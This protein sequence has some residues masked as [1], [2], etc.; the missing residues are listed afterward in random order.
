MNSANKKNILITGGAGYIGS[1]MVLCA[2]Q[3]G[4]N[5]VVLDSLVNGDKKFVNQKAK[6]IVGD[7]GDEAL[8]SRIISEEKISTIMHFAAFIEAGESVKNPEKYF[9]NNYEKSKILIETVV[10]LGVSNFIFSSTA[11][12]FGEAKYLPIDEEH[13]QDPIN[14]Y[15]KSKLMVEEFLA[16]TA[17]NN[18]H[19][20]YVCLRYFNACG[21]DYKNGLGENHNPETHLIPLLIKFVL[22]KRDEFFVNG[23]DYKTK[24][25][26]CIR[27]Y[28]HV[29]DICDAHLK[30][31]QYLQS[32][33]NSDCFNLG[34]KNG[35]S[36]LEI[37]SALEK[38]IGKKIFFKSANKREGDPASLVADNKKAEE[39]LL[40]KA[41]FSSL[42]E[43]INSAL[44]WEKI[45][46]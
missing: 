22:G 36:I 23:N 44:Q 35:F 6:L 17:K 11:A 42:N 37:I 15:G 28:I 1:H 12:I 46:V 3:N 10:K 13:P 38:I 29:L 27:D 4:F 14:P 7:V 16:K 33:G 26:T 34:S 45:N 18:P 43:I 5:V 32:G 20:K 31:L 9:L 30:S 2:I 19:F 39:I 40:W 41:R 25:G 8:V 24:D 21:A